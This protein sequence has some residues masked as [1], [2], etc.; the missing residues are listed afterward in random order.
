MAETRKGR[1]LGTPVRWLA[2][3]SQASRLWKRR[4]HPVPDSRAWIGL[5]RSVRSPRHV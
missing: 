2:A 1:S 4:F 5:A 3:A